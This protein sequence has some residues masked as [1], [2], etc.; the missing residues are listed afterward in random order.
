MIDLKYGVVFKGEL[1]FIPGSLKARKPWS[2]KA[3]FLC[4]K[5]IWLFNPQISQITP[6]TGKHF[7]AMRNL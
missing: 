4:N 5:L 6:I 7:I 1:F 2:K 3:G